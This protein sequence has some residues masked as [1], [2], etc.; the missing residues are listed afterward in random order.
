[1]AVACLL[2]P[3]APLFA[4]SDD[5]LI[6]AWTAEEYHLA[7]GVIHPVRGQI[8]FVDG[9]WQV[10]FFV[11]ADD[12]E[13]HRGSGEGGT[14][15]R[16]TEGVVFQHLFNLSVGEAL[17]GLDEA[18]LRMTV[19]SPEQAALEPTRVDVE[20]DILTLHFPSGNRMTFRRPPA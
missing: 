18:P 6:G 15:E 14:Y 1:M 4:Q 7:E 10:L 11:L 12:G 5:A 13:P 9:H 17:P 3:A 20:G 2:L 16:T 19:R 8:F